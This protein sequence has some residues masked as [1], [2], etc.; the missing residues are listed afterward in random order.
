MR[1]P[2]LEEQ[3]Y[4]YT[5]ENGLGGYKNEDGAWIAP[6]GTPQGNPNEVVEPEKPETIAISPIDFFT[7]EIAKLEPSI[8]LD[9]QDKLEAYLDLPKKK[10]IEGFI[11]KRS[12]VDFKQLVF[13][14]AILNRDKDSGELDPVIANLFLEKISEYKNAVKSEE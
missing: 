6:P 1:R 2:D 13:F 5:I 9:L 10:V 11:M 12:Q 8:A 3:G 4:T 7:K 14:E